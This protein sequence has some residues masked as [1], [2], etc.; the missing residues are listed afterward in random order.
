[1]LRMHAGATYNFLGPGLRAG[2][3]VVPFHFPIV[4]TLSLEYGHAFEAD[5][6]PLVSRFGKLSASE[7]TLLKR[8]GYDT[9]AAQVGIETGSPRSFAWFVRAGVAWVWVGVPNF[10]QAVQQQNPS[11]QSSSPKIRVTVPAVNVG[12]YL[13]F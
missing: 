4:P 1:M 8:V 2:A 12:F 3:T 11:M 6:G 5:A 9:L 7:R 10:D 13:Y